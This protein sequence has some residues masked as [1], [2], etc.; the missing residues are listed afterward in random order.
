MIGGGVAGVVAAAGAV[1]LNGPGSLL[2]GGGADPGAPRI[3]LF[4][5]ASVAIVGSGPQLPA[6]QFSG[7]SSHVSHCAH[8]DV[9]A[10]KKPMSTKT[11]DRVMLVSFPTSG[12]ATTSLRSRRG[13]RSCRIATG[14]AASCTRRFRFNAH[15]LGFVAVITIKPQ[16]FG[17]KLLRIRLFRIDGLGEDARSGKACGPDRLFGAAAPGSEWCVPP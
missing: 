13:R 5:L 16:G 2:V 4:M 7:K 9:T 10:A 8:P 3:G 17:G 11:M 12:F 6:V 14:R 1:A 15:R